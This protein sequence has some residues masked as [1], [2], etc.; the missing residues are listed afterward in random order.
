MDVEFVEGPSPDERPQVIRHD[1]RFEAR[2]DIQKLY[3]F[4]NAQQSIPTKIGCNISDSHS[5]HLA[6][7]TDETVINFYIPAM[8]R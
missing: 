3:S 2:I 7:H 5:L 8:I 6:F 4:L 1:E